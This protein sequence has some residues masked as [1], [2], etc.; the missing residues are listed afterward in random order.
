MPVM[1][2]FSKETSELTGK[3]LMI[4]GGIS[5]GLHLLLLLGLM[6]WMG[7][8]GALFVAAG[9]GEGGGDGGGAIQVGIAEASE[10]GFARPRVVSHEGKNK[11]ETVN[12]VRLAQERQ[13]DEEKELNLD[14]QKLDPEARK[15]RLPVAA[16]EERLYSQK[17]REGAS[18]S[19]TAISG[20]SYGSRKPG[21]V[22]GIGIGSGANPFGTGLPGGSEYGRRVQSILSRNFT[23]SQINVSGVSNV[24]IYVKIARDGRITSV[25]NGRVPRN[26]FKAS[27]PHEMLNFAAERA[28]IA[29]AAQ[30]L[31]P[32]PAGFL[33]GVEEAVAEVWFQY[34]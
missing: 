16:K 30:G 33:G 6:F 19:T 26:Y 21:I 12:N 10:L 5:A 4:W 22:G 11:D 1:A 14:K 7:R 20:T 27:S 23:P 31:P 34:P 18:S 28:I 25:V 15:T 9:E 13:E 3:R 2:N 17:P 24:I 8:A 29:T 32:F